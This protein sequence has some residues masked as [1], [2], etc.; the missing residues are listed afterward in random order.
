MR[1]YLPY[2]LGFSILILLPPATVNG[3][4][5]IPVQVLTA[6]KSSREERA[7]FAEKLASF[8]R[9]LNDDIPNLTPQEAEWLQ[10]ETERIRRS[11]S[12]Q[13]IIEKTLQLEKSREWHTARAKE[14]LEKLEQEVREIAKYIRADNIGFVSLEMV[15]WV[16]F[17]SNELM[18]NPFDH[19]LEL[20]LHYRLPASSTLPLWAGW[21]LDKVVETPNEIAL[22]INDWIVKPY[23]EDHE[24]VEASEK[25]NTRTSAG[26]SGTNATS[27]K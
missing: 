5:Q 8:F 22:T 20:V 4:T 17:S 19:Y 16:R 13:A 23:L 2:L 3:T 1:N 10:K 25:S 24:F 27:T 7:K 9:Q 6:L 11:T 15:K 21:P 26:V 14:Q 18:V 12:D